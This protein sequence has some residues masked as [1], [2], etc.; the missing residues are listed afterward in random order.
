VCV[1]VCGYERVSVDAPRPEPSGHTPPTPG[2][3][4]TDGCEP[5]DMGTGKNTCVLCKA[6]GC[7]SLLSHL[8]C[9]WLLVCAK[10][11][12]RG[13]PQP[14]AILGTESLVF[15]VYWRLAGLST[16]RDPQVSAPIFLYERWD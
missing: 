1:S 5:S 6:S 8:F 14:F 11:G 4:I 15:P 2:S 16:S 13:Q 12:V 10:V 7:F 9:L 3:G